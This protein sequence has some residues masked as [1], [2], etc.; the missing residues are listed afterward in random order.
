[1]ELELASRFGDIEDHICD[2]VS[3]NGRFHRQRSFLENASRA[4]FDAWQL[5]MDASGKAYTLHDRLRDHGKETRT[6]REQF[7]R[8]CNGRLQA[9]INR[10][11]GAL[12]AD[13]PGFADCHCENEH[14]GQ[15]WQLKVEGANIDE[16]M[17]ELQRDLHREAVDKIR[18][19][20]EELAKEMELLSAEFEAPELK[21]GRIRNHRK[22]LGLGHPGISRSALGWRLG[23]PRDPVRAVGPVSQGR[24]SWRSDI[25]RPSLPWEVRR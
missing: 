20:G 3:H 1:M 23:G 12:R 15:L 17:Q 14:I 7:R 24:A 10:T 13:I 8:R 2:E 6:W 25:G 9:L 16:Q 19:L 4:S 11:V 18:T 22:N 5:M 21:G